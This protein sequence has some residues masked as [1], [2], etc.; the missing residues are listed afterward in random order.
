[1]NRSD[2]F[3]ASL[4]DIFRKS[5]GAKYEPQKVSSLQILDRPRLSFNFRIDIEYSIRARVK[6]T[7]YFGKPFIA[8][9]AETQDEHQANKIVSELENDGYGAKAELSQE[10]RRLG[11]AGFLGGEEI[12]LNSR[13]LNVSWSE[14]CEGCGGNG[15]LRCGNC[16]GDGQVKCFSCYG[17]SSVQCNL[18]GGGGYSE[19]RDHYGNVV[20]DS[21]FGCG[22]SG[23][24]R[25]PHCLNGLQRCPGCSGGGEIRCR[26]CDG[27]GAFTILKTIE[28]YARKLAALEVYAGHG[29]SAE[30]REWHEMIGR[31]AGSDD[32]TKKRFFIENAELDPII[33][34]KDEFLGMQAYQITGRVPTRRYCIEG[35]QMK[36][37]LGFFEK[38]AYLFDGD[39]V[40][41]ES[42][43]GSV[44]KFLS[45]AS[46]FGAAKDTFDIPV[47]KRILKDYAN[48]LEAREIETRNRRL[49][50]SYYIDHLTENA[51][52]LRL[53]LRRAKA[54]SFG[55]VL[56]ALAFPLLVGLHVFFNSLHITVPG[57]DW[58][59]VQLP[60]VFDFSYT[61]VVLENAP[62]GMLVSGFVFLA[63]GMVLLPYLE[64]PGVGW[65]GRIVLSVLYC[66]IWFIVLVYF[67]F[68]T[69]ISIPPEA[70]FGFQQL[71]IVSYMEA[72]RWVGVHNLYTV[73]LAFLISAPLALGLVKRITYRRVEKSVGGVL[74]NWVTRKE[75]DG[76][77]MRV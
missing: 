59:M 57:F 58:E 50:P 38:T 37:E 11:Y 60:S 44:E 20:Q 5:F 17:T 36:H 2:P 1:M 67:A 16:Y 25:C 66:F 46:N 4:D 18:C 64:M 14:S 70:S 7:K 41:V 13:S 62:A 3:M 72:A 10:V 73:T 35:K 27:H 32:A 12:P 69:I 75:I 55:G 30:T 39:G 24:M 45:D 6:R 26:S 71:S 53:E 9:S 19:N 31:L 21:C 63:I 40:L 22:G 56:I 77:R 49:V 54:G 42:I 68:P 34:P 43:P 65:V 76:K 61:T 51:E 23:S 47:N 74:A 52:K 29:G 8:N 33:G 15:T 48:G 28:P